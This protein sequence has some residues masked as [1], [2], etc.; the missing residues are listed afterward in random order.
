MPQ[1][2]DA[3]KKRFGLTIDV[4]LTRVAAANQFP[5]EIAATKAGAPPTYDVMQ[6]ADAETMQFYGDGGLQPIPQWE[7]LLAAV[8]GEVAARKVAPDQISRGPLRGVS[9][10]YMA[11]VK[12]MLYNPKLI[13]AKDLP[14]LH[15]DLVQA[16]FAGKFTQPPWT[17]HWEI[18]A[19][20]VRNVGR[21]AF[22]D[23]V[24]AAGKNAAAVLPE[25]EGVQRVVLGQYA[26]TLAQ[27]TYLAQVLARDRQAP[28]AGAFFHDYNELNDVYYSVRAHALH[29][30]AA[31]L[32]A[33]WMTTP[34]AEAI[35]Q[36]TARS[37]VPYGSSPFDV[38]ERESI[39]R[40]GAPVVGYLDSAQMIAYLKWQ[41]T[42]EG[43]AYLSAM[44]R[45]IRGE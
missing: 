19:P 17:S 37:F 14:R 35:W 42:D 12:E 45:A 38:A 18:A 30:A 41:Q 9:F 27:D 16:R 1:L 21:E 10:L 43:R 34:E 36:P 23:V 26:F 4:S 25:S 13:A 40:G 32:W 44:A 8:N 5:L 28:L 31:A 22:L 11:N 29:P 20:V 33:M 2:A 3:F 7:T 15:T 6:S 39:R 24:R